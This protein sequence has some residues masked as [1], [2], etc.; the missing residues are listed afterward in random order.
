MQNY[1]SNTINFTT[2]FDPAPASL[3][4]T[5]DEFL[6]SLSSPT[7]I[8]IPG[9]DSSRKRVLVTLIHG[10]E[11]SG[12]YATYRLLQQAVKPAV[13]LHIL[14][15]SVITAK[16]QPQFS[17]RML[18]G[19]RDLNRCFDRLGE[20]DDESQ[21]AQAVL[22]LLDEL[23]PEAV[24]DLHNTSG[25]GPAFGVATN[26]DPHIE[27]LVSMFT[28]RLVL[29]DLRLGAL[30]EKSE[31]MRPI[32]TVECGGSHDHESHALAFHGL[33]KFA[34]AEDVWISTD[35]RPMD[36]FQNPM[37]AELTAG[38]TLS[39]D[40]EA[41]AN[42]DLTLVRHIEDFNFGIVDENTVLGFCEE[43]TLEK[44]F[45]KNAAGTAPIQQFFRVVGGE[46]RP[47]MPLKLFM[48]TTNITIAQSDCLY[49]F[50][51]VP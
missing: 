36:L 25:S 34:E 46:L 5:V 33:L 38:T 20:Q 19:K 37:R 22:N 45:A 40:D 1:N 17:H 16:A 28:K 42:C 7:H 32:V 10:N 50:V 48:I 31:P 14:L 30:M 41:V 29:T 47:L 6:Q 21:L 11:P 3:P 24:I 2:L 9:R 4:S 44:V 23:Q 12:F 15:P 39:Y 13:D 49:Y 8:V 51:T 26:T 18:P 43:S 35:P 27:A